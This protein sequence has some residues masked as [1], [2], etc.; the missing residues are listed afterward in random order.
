MPPIFVD[1]PPSNGG[2]IL[3]YGTTVVVPGGFGESLWVYKDFK[4]LIWS[5]IAASII[6][7]Y[8]VDFIIFSS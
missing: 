8:S 3:L 6:L 7:N 2:S 5:V 4:V 1:G